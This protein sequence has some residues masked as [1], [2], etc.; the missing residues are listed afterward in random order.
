MIP[1]IT[2]LISYLTL[3]SYLF[4][5]AVWMFMYREFKALKAEIVD[6]RVERAKDAGVEQGQDHER[7][8]TRLERLINGRP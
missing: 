4:G 6:M 2:D 7:R 3:G 8:L 1:S 5:A